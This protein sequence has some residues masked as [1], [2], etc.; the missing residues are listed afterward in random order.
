MKKIK[1]TLS[2]LL[3]F[4]IAFSA[5]PLSAFAD[6]SFEFGNITY[7]FTSIYGNEYGNTVKN[8]VV[9]SSEPIVF[10]NLDNGS[11]ETVFN[12]SGTRGD[13]LI[14][15]YS[16]I[17]Y[18]GF[19][20]SYYTNIVYRESN[21]KLLTPNK[22]YFSLSTNNQAH[23]EFE[24]LKDLD[25]YQIGVI[26]VLTNKVYNDS[27]AMESMNI[28]INGHY[29]VT[30]AKTGLLNTILEWLQNIRDKIV[31]LPNQ[32]GSFITDLKTNMS[33]W[34]TDLGNNIK[35][36][37]TELS[38]NLKDWFKN[39]GD[40]FS[41]LG[42]SIGNFF[43]NLWDNISSSVDNIKLDISNWWNSVKEWFHN[44]FVPEDGWITDYRFRLSSFLDTHLGLIYQAPQLI[45]SIIYIVSKSFNTP[46]NGKVI[47][48]EIKLPF[49][50]IKLCDY[51]EFDLNTIINSNERFK[52]FYNTFKLASSAIILLLVINYC[53][54]ELEEF[55]KDREVSE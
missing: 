22:A 10:K 47:I 13:H 17:G 24:L 14:I 3:C 40:W 45:S 12:I 43:S 1:Q 19:D 8:N 46:A 42:E 27:I 32:F 11:F 38:N 15:E 34:F 33:S 26:G 2:I 50:N 53:R 55:L 30:D 39:V 37:F 54:K 16:L 52:W 51:T 48:P 7:K 9:A 23:F 18:N 4:I 28:G 5:F 29:I 41:N 36:T 35:S 25:D 44:L 6:S 21:L 20:C 49:N 31:D